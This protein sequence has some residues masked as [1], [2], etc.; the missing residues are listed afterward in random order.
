MHV[1]PDGA[2]GHQERAIHDTLQ[3]G[4]ETDPRTAKCRYEYAGQEAEQE[5]QGPQADQGARVRVVRHAENSAAPAA[6]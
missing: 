4:R 1:M 5:E 3:M 6:T 2:Q